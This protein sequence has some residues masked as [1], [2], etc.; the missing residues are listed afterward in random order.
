MAR[1]RGQTIGVAEIVRLW[2]SY[3]RCPE[4]PETVL[5][6]DVDAND[7]TRVRRTTYARCANR[8]AVTLYRI[9]G[10]GHTWPGGPQYLPRA[11]IGRTSRDIEATLLIWQFF[12]GH[13]RP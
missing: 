1:T 5:L 4:G 11:V 13:P 10:G 9:E 12:A 6:P 3:N 7:G 2:T 8:T